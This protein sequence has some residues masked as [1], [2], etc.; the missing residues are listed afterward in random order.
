MNDLIRNLEIFCGGFVQR[1][2]RMIKRIWNYTVKFFIKLNDDHLGAYSSQSAYFIILSFIPFLLLLTTL[3]RYLPITEDL[4]TTD[5]ISVLPTNIQG[6]VQGIV[7]EVYAKSSAVLPITA[8]LA[9]WSAGKGFQAL[10]NGLNVINSVQETRN[11]FYM[12]IRSALYTIVFIVSIVLTLVLMV[13]GR[14]IQKLLVEWWPFVA[15]ITNYILKF[16]TIL[17]MFGLAFIFLMFY[18][19]L[20]NRKQHILDQIPGAL[21]ASVSWSV[22]SFGFSMYLEYFPGFA[23]MYG[24]LTTIILLMLWLYFCMNLFLLGAEINVVLEEPENTDKVKELIGDMVE[25]VK[26]ETREMIYTNVEE[27]MRELERK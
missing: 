20:P 2:K 1:G 24:S 12:R 23:D 21:F 26:S 4:I 15:E 7:Q 14:S 16:S 10:T 25:E 13:F 5:I 11:Y 18:T 9:L 27:K 22:F 17:T 3:L 19:F 8:I 6:F